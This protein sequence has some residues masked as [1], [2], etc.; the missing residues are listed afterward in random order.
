MGETPKT[1]EELQNDV[2][3]ALQLLRPVYDASSETEDQNIFGDQAIEDAINNARK[4]IPLVLD[5]AEVWARQLCVFATVVNVQ[6][7]ALDTDIVKVISVLY[8]V[9]STGIRNANTV[10]ATE[11]IDQQDESAAIDDPLN[12][13]SA[14]NPKYRLSHKGIRIIT[15]TDGTQTA[16]KYV[17]VEFVGGMTALSGASDSSGVPQIINTLTTEWALYLLTRNWDKEF[18]EKRMAA[19]YQIVSTLNQRSR[20]NGKIFSNA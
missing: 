16:S 12:A 10:E 9:E 14:T 17:A 8:D 1:F 5:D 15:S 13:P 19:F 3:R 20:R 2:K 6:D 7:Y 11:I 18:S 4:Q